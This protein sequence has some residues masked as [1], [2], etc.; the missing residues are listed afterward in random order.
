MAGRNRNTFVK[1]QKEMERVQ[2]ARAK[3]A[4]RHGGRAAKAGQDADERPAEAG[5]AVAVDGPNPEGAE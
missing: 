3:M 4:R 1:R 2:R 5:I